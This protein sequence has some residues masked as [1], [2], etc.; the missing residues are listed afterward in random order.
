MT[1]QGWKMVMWFAIGITLGALYLWWG[2]FYYV[3][4]KDCENKGMIN[5]KFEAPKGKFVAPA[6]NKVG[7]SVQN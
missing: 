4:C 7:P 2:S 6:D 5:Y 3:P 1:K